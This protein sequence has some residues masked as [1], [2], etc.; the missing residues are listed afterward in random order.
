MPKEKEVD[1]YGFYIY[2][3]DIEDHWTPRIID[4]ADKELRSW[5]FKSDEI[6]IPNEKI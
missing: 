1:P 6:I 5:I 4:Y 3:L 2:Y